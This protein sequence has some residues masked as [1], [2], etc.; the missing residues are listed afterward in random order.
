[1]KVTIEKIGLQKH[2]VVWYHAQ[3]YDYRELFE[4][5]CL[6][7]YDCLDGC[8]YLNHDDLHVAT[9]LPALPRYPQPEDAKLLYRYMAEGLIPRYEY[10]D[11]DFRNENE[12]G[13]DILWW[14]THK[15]CCGHK[16]IEILFCIDEEDNK[17][18]KVSLALQ[19]LSLGKKVVAHSI[20]AAA[21]GGSSIDESL[22]LVQ[23]I[24]E[25]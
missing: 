21:T 16:E 5:L 20:L 17:V 12:L 14:F 23:T 1:M 13:G 15:L 25:N 18:G 19:G 4:A 24:Y 3:E 9:A 10:I 11:P 8:F 22:P 2:T 6:G 7:I